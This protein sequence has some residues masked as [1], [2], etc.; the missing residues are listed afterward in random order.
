MLD[1]LRAAE[2][3]QRDRT[4]GLITDSISFGTTTRNLIRGDFC[5]PAKL[6]K[7]NPELHALFEQLA[8]RAGAVYRETFPNRYAAHDR[9][10][11]ERFA[12]EYR[13]AGTPWNA[14]TANRTAVLPLHRDSGNVT[15]HWT[16][17]TWICSSGSGPLTIPGFG[18]EI[19]PETGDLLLFDGAVEE[20]GVPT[21]SGERFSV[22]FYTRACQCLSA[23]EELERYQTLC[24]KRERAL[25][26]GLYAGKKP[27]LRKL[28]LRAAP[29]LPG[30]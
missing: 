12:P 4:N 16:A 5:R 24:T 1:R 25:R 26:H 30:L 3:S 18:I 17:I 15:E 19:H 11:S 2:W 28:A 21:T 13:L 27:E 9:A 7:T 23:A 22:V 10:A 8:G 6:L 29:K 20:H 14:G